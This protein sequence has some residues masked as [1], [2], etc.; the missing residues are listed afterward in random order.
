MKTVVDFKI[1]TTE[2]VFRLLLQLTTT[3]LHGRTVPEVAEELM[4]RALI[5]EIGR[6]RAGGAT[7]FI[8][9]HEKG[10]KNR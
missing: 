5:D 10:R 8:R 9:G 7:W 6:A 4:R 2:Q 3:G 1:E